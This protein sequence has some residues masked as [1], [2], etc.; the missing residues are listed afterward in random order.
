MRWAGLETDADSGKKRKKGRV[1]ERDFAQWI[2]AGQDIL[3]R[4]KRDSALQVLKGT[5]VA[6]DS[7]KELIELVAEDAEALKCKDRILHLR[8]IIKR[9]TS[10]HRQLSVYEKARMT[11]KSD[12]EALIAVVDQLIAETMEMG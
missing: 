9:G 8:T 11:G 2:R 10:A 6:M 7:K 12:K 3:L 5:S 4:R 1:T